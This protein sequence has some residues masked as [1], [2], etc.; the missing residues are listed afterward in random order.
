[1]QAQRSIDKAESKLKKTNLQVNG[2]SGI[3]NNGFYTDDISLSISSQSE[4]S[5]SYSHNR[6]QSSKPSR[7]SRMEKRRLDQLRF[8]QIFNNKKNQQPFN[9]NTTSKSEIRCICKPNQKHFNCKMCTQNYPILVRRS[10]NGE[11]GTIEWSDV[12]NF[13][14]SEDVNGEDSSNSS[15]S[16][17]N[18]LDIKKK[19]NPE[20]RFNNNSNHLISPSVLSIL[21]LSKPSNTF[22]APP[23]IS[24]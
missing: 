10:A 13:V 24:L 5:Y 22:I 2:P 14:G 6:S 23:N 18:T 7:Q 3:T 19:G 17:T 12:V 20:I 9:K 1:M 4:S 11:S 21:A 15:Q 8:E 16:S